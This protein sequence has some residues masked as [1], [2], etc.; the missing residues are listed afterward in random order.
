VSAGAGLKWKVF[1]NTEGTE[2]GE[3][4][5]RDFIARKARDGAEVLA[6]QADTFAGSE[7]RGKNVGLLRS[8]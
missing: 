6:A 1:L 3:K 8:K 2:I 7:R 5:K 4:E